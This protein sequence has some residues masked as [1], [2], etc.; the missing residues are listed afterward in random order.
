MMRARAS[1]CPG[2]SR[3]S[4]SPKSPCCSSGGSDAPSEVADA[5]YGYMSAVI[6]SPSARAASM[7]WTAPASLLQFVR[8]ACLK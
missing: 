2:F 6:A 1:G 4:S 8:P 7:R 5:M 3:L